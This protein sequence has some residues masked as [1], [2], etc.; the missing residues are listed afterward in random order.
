[1]Q[2]REFGGTGI[3]LSR[4][5]LGCFSMSGAYGA[6]DDAESIATI[7]RAMER[8]V[9]LL[10]T[11]ARYGGG[12]NHQ[13]IGEAIKGR[14]DQ[15]FIHS[16]TGTIRNKGDRSVAEGSGTP[17]RL[18]SICEQSLKNL[19]V[20]YLDAM[21]QSRVDPTVPI[22]ESVGAV[23]RLV[24]EGK[25]RF[26]GLSEAAPETVRRASAVH[27][28]VSL[29]FEYSLW[30]RDV[31][32]GH[33]QACEELEMALMAY[34]PLGYGFL[35]GV[36]DRAGAQS[37][38][39]IRG[40]FPRFS[41]ENFETNREKV[42][43]LESFAAEKQSTAAQICLAWLLAHNDNVFPIPGCKSRKH[44][45]ENLDAIEIVL[46]ED[47]LARLDRIFPKDAASGDRYP[48]GGMKRVNL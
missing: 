40:K 41:E 6:A 46:T 34:A 30:T 29:Q 38:D 36:V 24:E 12:H 37:E 27:S 48:P 35:A 13:L 1:M 20:D 43:Q 23:A 47:D 44:L 5:G 45:D 17:D 22:E 11:S 19:G 25:V 21:C 32:Q 9:N 10:D 16:K 15:I 18:R 8:G 39:D 7:H 14:R 28:L 26:I 4:I 42:T 31:E 3:Q 2:Y 33:R